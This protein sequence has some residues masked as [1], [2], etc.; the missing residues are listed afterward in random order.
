MS[1]KKVLEQDKQIAHDHWLQLSLLGF[2]GEFH[3]VDHHGCIEDLEDGG[4]G[5]SGL[6]LNNILVDQDE[7]SFA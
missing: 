1:E 6:I 4:Q 3:E 5:L 7:T 2:L